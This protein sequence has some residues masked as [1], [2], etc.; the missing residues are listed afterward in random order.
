MIFDYANLTQLITAK[1]GSMSA[2]AE[3]AGI[4]TAALDEYLDGVTPWP[5]DAKDRTVKVLG[6]P[7]EYIPRYFFIYQV[8]PGKPK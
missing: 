2:F 1:C 7:D 5:Q 4:D 6:I 3:R 8:D